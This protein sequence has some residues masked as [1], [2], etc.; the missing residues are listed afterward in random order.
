MPLYFLLTQSINYFYFSEFTKKNSKLQTCELIY[1]SVL[2]FEIIPFKAF[3]TVASSV[4]SLH[5]PKVFIS[6]IGENGEFE[7]T[8]SIFVYHFLIDA[9]IIEF[10]VE[11]VMSEY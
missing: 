2:K 9:V 1:Y 4:T 5:I 11:V 7:Y 10:A 6:K 3:G 8:I